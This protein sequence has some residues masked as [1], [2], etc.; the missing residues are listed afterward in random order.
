MPNYA[1]PYSTNTIHKLKGCTNLTALSFSPNYT[2]GLNGDNFDIISGKTT[3]SC[4]AIQL[5][6]V[7]KLSVSKGREMIVS[8]FH[9]VR[10]QY[11][12]K[13]DIDILRGRRLP[14]GQ[15]FENF[16]KMKESGSLGGAHR[17]CFHRFTTKNQCFAMV[18]S[19]LFT[20]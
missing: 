9:I 2:V 19:I 8:F 5:F 14:I 18:M 10:I 7:P 4:V 11:F 1:H 12:P 20:F 16:V 3:V 17:C 15:R 13:G 6:F